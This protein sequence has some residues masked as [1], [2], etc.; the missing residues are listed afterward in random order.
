[1]TGMQ[2]VYGFGSQV[3]HHHLMMFL[4]AQ[5]EEHHQTAMLLDRAEQ[6]QCQIG[7]IF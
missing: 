2:H 7:F 1:M 3:K 5:S 4:S 6:S